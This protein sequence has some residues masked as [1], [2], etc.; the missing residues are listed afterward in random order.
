LINAGVP[1]P[2]VNDDFAGRAPDI[3]A[4]DFSS[5]LLETSEW[6]CRGR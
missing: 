1:L 2:G 3:G 5:G 4:V 6:D